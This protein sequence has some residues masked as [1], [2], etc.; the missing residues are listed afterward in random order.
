VVTDSQLGG[1]ADLGTARESSGVERNINDYLVGTH[2]L[3]P[4]VAGVGVEERQ[5]RS[6]VQR[7]GGSNSVDNASGGAFIVGPPDQ[8]NDG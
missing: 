6:L 7:P 2:W 1:G 3:E 5:E 8:R 4:R